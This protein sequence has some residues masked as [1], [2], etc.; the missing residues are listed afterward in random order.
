M[1]TPEL[2]AVLSSRTV[3]TFALVDPGDV[4]RLVPYRWRLH[5]RGYAVARI[6]GTETLMHRFLLAPADGLEVDHVNRCKLD[7]RRCNL[8]VV[9]RRENSQNL[10]GFGGSSPYRGVFARGARFVAKVR[11]DGVLQ[12]LG[13]FDTEREAAEAA[14]TFRLEH[15]AGAMPE[16]E[17]AA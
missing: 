11:V 6:N 4:D 12:H 13:T 14:E 16:L 7:N 15:M 5:P 10:A 8:R 1:T 17:E 9:T 3:P 2:I